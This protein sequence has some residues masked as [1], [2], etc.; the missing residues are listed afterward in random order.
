MAWTALAEAFSEV[1]NEALG[2]LFGVVVDR[3]FSFADICAISQLEG[4]RA[5][6]KQLYACQK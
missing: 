1:W 6:Q 4:R 3:P 2:L 5:G